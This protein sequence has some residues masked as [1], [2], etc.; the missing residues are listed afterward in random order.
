MGNLRAGGMR[1]Q[2]RS[3]ACTCS[4]RG[5]RQIALCGTACWAIVAPS[6]FGSNKHA[7][8]TDFKDSPGRGAMDTV[9]VSPK[10]HTDNPAP[11]RGV[12]TVD[13]VNASFSP[14]PERTHGA[15]S[16]QPY[17]A[18]FLVRGGTYNP[19]GTIRPDRT[20]IDDTHIPK[21]FAVKPIKPNSWGVNHRAQVEVRA[22]D[23]GAHFDF[24]HVDVHTATSGGVTRLLVEIPVANGTFN[25]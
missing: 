4:V 5:I 10:C 14:D 11:H 15:S 7:S 20:K 17:V 23:G 3:Q 8:A 9:K 1:R 16:G 21:D 13:A 2:T 18:S 25:P 12:I 19:P 24:A 6:A 22:K